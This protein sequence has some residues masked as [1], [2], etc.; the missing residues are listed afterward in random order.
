MFVGSLLVCDVLVVCDDLV[1]DKYFVGLVV[2]KFVG[3]SFVVAVEVACNS[4]AD[5]DLLEDI[6]IVDIEVEQ[7][8]HMDLGTA[9]IPFAHIEVALSNI[10]HI[11]DTF[12]VI[13]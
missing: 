8:I 6:H 12:F 10:V 9:D 11:L 4:V 7:N 1:V 2:D 13:L 5:I 3:S